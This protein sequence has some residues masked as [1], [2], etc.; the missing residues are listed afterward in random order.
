M[1]AATGTRDITYNLVSVLY[2]AL[3]EGDT[4][5]EYIDDALSAGDDEVA[6]FFTEVQGQNRAR[7]DRAK[8]LLRAKLVR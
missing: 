3:Q 7:A 4:L 5:Q 1:T 6:S 2:H 8:D